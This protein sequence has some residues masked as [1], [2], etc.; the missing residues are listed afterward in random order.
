VIFTLIFE[1][2]FVFDF[3]NLKEKNPFMRKTLSIPLEPLS[4]QA[5]SPFGQVLMP[6]PG[7]PADTS[8]AGW[9]CWYPLAR[10]AQGIDWQIGLVRTEPRPIV[11]D[12]LE[13]HLAR[14]EWVLALDKPLIQ[15]VALSGPQEAGAP[16]A[17]TSKAFL[18]QPGQGV[19]LA[20][21]VWHGVGLPAGKETTQYGFVLAAQPPD[22]HENSG[23]VSFSGN[24]TV[25]ISV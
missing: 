13:R 3:G 14:P 12:A 22:P 21:G 15:T 11:L 24:V 1:I 19:L 9:Q 16:D 23:W 4:P 6:L 25:K 17:S 2:W 18:I 5:F 8:G 10:M 7:Q 20:A